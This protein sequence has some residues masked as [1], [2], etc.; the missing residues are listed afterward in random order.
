MF[1]IGVFEMPVCKLTNS[2]QRRV[3]WYYRTSSYQNNC[4]GFTAWSLFISY[5][6]FQTKMC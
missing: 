3:R 1:R 6:G 4:W 5:N 2:N